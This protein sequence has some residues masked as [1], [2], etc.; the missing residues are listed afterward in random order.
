MRSCEDRTC[1]AWI[2]A[3]PRCA[4]RTSEHADVRSANLAGAML[5]GADVT[6]ANVTGA[7][8]GGA[9]YDAHTRWP[10]GFQTQQHGAGR[11]R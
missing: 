4:T 11:V 10:T 6:H 2:S 7:Q 8:F 5:T 9:C 3:P 1:A